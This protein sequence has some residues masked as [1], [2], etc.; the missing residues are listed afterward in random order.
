MLVENLTGGLL[1]YSSL[2]KLTR[3]IL[4]EAAVAIIG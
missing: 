3:K 2:E 1:L 4:N